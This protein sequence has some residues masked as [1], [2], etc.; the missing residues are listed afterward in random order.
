MRKNISGF[1][2]AISEHSLGLIRIFH[3]ITES[4]ATLL[5]SANEWLDTE[6]DE[7]VC[8]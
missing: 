4:L 2:S 8:L 1:R 6:M 7:T 5:I 3:Y